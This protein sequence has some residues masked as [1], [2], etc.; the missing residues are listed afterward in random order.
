MQQHCLRPGTGRGQAV[1]HGLRVAAAADQAFVF[2][3]GAL[4]R[5][6]RRPEAGRNSQLASCH[7][8]IKQ[9][10]HDA[11]ARRMRKGTQEVG[12]LVGSFSKFV[13]G[14]R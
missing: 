3:Y 6:S 11:Q 12:C 1:V 7:F 5:Q 2:Q 14:A 9:G 13:H 4:L 8:A 10:T